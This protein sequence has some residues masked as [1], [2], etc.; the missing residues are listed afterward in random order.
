MKHVAVNAVHHLVQFF[1]N[2]MYKVVYRHLFRCGGKFNDGFVK[3]FLPS[4][5]VKEF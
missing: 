3:R 4:L 1:K 2:N 5:S